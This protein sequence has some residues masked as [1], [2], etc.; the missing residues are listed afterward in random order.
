MFNVRKQTFGGDKIW[1]TW[2]SLYVFEKIFN[3]YKPDLIIELGTYTGASAHFF[4]LF[5]P[6]ITYDI[7]PKERNGKTYPN[8][9]YRIK[10]LFK[11]KTIEEISKLI[12]SHNKVFIFLDNGT[13]REKQWNI[14]ASLIKKGDL[15]F[16]HG[17]KMSIHPKDVNPLISKLK[18]KPYRKELCDKYKSLLQGW[19]R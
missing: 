15:V 3:E 11:E 14:Y 1:Q 6:V 18:L 7:S 10:D 12:K 4:S 9:D 2:S 13:P 5:A 8:I 16:V 19:Q 17:W